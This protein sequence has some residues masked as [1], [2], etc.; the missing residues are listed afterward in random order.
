[1]FKRIKLYFD[2]KKLDKLVDAYKGQ[3]NVEE[4]YIVD[5]LINNLLHYSFKSVDISYNSKRVM[6]A[7][8]V[9][10]AH[11]ILM[12]KNVV[13]FDVSIDGPVLIISHK[14]SEN[15]NGQMVPTV[16]T[17]E[18]KIN[19]YSRRLQ[20]K[21]NS[22]VISDLCKLGEEEQEYFDKTIKEI[23]SNIYAEIVDDILFAM[24]SKA[25]NIHLPP[26]KESDHITLVD[27]I[28]K[29]AISIAVKTR[30]GM[31]NFI[32][33]NQNFFDLIK[34]HPSFNCLNYEEKDTT[35][36]T[37]VFQGKLQSLS[38]FVQSDL[39]DRILLGYVGKSK[40]F[41]NGDLGTEE[42]KVMHDAGMVYCG[43]KLF[44]PTRVSNTNSL[45]P[46]NF[47]TYSGLIDGNS[48]IKDYYTAIH[49]K[50]IK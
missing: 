13:A 45:Y 3:F 38:I 40:S 7:I 28:I 30:R 17:D 37:L 9:Q 34:Q 35:T 21:I 4:L 1:M 43:N 50:I 44:F 26:I 15:A 47:F 36:S 16:E 8:Y 39:K 49:V 5:T 10:L 20:T 48:K 12:L 32:I 27:E 14:L 19:L 29:A 11:K 33:C 25:A 24:K 42:Y 41:R 23:A 22:D 2:N 46:Y 6:L 18:Y 31:A